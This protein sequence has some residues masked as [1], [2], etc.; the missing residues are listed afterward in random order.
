MENRPTM[1]NGIAIKGTREGLTITLGSGEVTA[2][3]DE[4]ARH[5]EAQGAFFRDGQVALRTNDL[6]VR[7]KDLERISALLAEHAMVLRT[8]VTTN[9]T[10]RQAAD[11]LGLRVL[12]SETPA[13]APAAAPAPAPRPQAPA[14]SRPVVRA[15]DATRAT[16]IHQI[17]RSGQVIRS[18][19]HVVVVGDVNPGGE[20]VAGG[21]VIIWGRLRGIV[22]AGA[23]GNA[24]A[25][26]CALDFAP[27]QLRIGEYI[28]RSADD[29][30]RKEPFPEMATVRDDAI[31]V[32]PWNRGTRGRATA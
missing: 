23:M 7:Q 5:L 8:V 9:D 15:A 1:T 10:T 28:A 26:V 16:L 4:L 2:M 25:M 29:E 27:M 21:D 17:V 13:P 24:S 14:V 11:G 12:S 22:H 3:L 18:T 32:E 30:K 6:A 20:I 31:I 19:G